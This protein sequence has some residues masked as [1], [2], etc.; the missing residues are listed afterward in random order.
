M[1]PHDDRQPPRLDDWG[2]ITAPDG[3]RHRVGHV[4]GHPRLIDGRTVITA[5]L[6]WIAADRAAARPLNTLDARGRAVG[7]GRR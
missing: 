1:P 5:P 7:A 6:V 2:V 3:A 4:S